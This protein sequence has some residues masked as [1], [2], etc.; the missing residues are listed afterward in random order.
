M[1]VVLWNAGLVSGIRRWSEIGMRMAIGETRRH[2]IFTLL[3][4]AFFT[5]LAGTIVGIILGLPVAYY[6]QEVGLDYSSELKDI[7]LMMNTVMRAR[8]VPSAFY[9]SMI[10]GIF[11]SLLGTLMS[12]YGVWTR[13]TAALF[14][15]ME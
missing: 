8:I 6:F 7:S 5:G 4:E 13:Q 12:C 1:A 3:V 15:E 2:I 14:K 11:A 9:Y 10:P